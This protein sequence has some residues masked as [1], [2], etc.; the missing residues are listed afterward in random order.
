[1]SPGACSD[2][3]VQCLCGAGS[4]AV[5]ACPVSEK[6]HSG[7]GLRELRDP[8][9]G[10]RDQ[11]RA[12]RRD[13]AGL[14]PRA[15]LRDPEEGSETPEQGSEIRAGLEAG[16]SCCADGQSSMAPCA[17]ALILPGS[18]TLQG[19]HAG[20]GECPAHFYFCWVFFFHI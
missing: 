15:G 17:R 20:G 2:I 10:L 6:K 13:T 16:Q 18:A 12:Q 8:R 7:C 11:N 14:R 5:T 4:E 19:R 9:T 1:M 3:S